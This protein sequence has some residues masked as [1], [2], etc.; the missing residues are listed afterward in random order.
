MHDCKWFCR[1]VSGMVEQ[2]PLHAPFADAHSP[3]LFHIVPVR[4]LEHGPGRPC[5]AVLD[6]Y[7]QDGNSLAKCQPFDDADPVSDPGAETDGA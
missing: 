5:R 2:Q 6:A 1:T 3:D 7:V 4:L